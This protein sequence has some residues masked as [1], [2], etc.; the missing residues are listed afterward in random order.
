MECIYQPLPKI[1][2]E[3]VLRLSE[4]SFKIINGPPINEKTPS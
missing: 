1:I 2:A 3:V 4:K